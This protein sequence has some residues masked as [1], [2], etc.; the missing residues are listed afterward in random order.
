MHT[1]YIVPLSLAFFSTITLC[2]LTLQMGLFF[3]NRSHKLRENGTTIADEI[4]ERHTNS[5]YY[6]YLS[7]SLQI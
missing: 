1:F 7:N 2:V 5:A 4:L 6:S 3:I